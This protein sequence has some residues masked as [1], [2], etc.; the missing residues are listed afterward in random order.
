MR[1]GFLCVVGECG[2]SAVAFAPLAADDGVDLLLYSGEYAFGNAQSF[3]ANGIPI[4]RNFLQWFGQV[5]DGQRIEVSKEFR[6]VNG[7][8]CE[9]GF[10]RNECN[11]R[12]VPAWVIVLLSL[13]I[14]RI[15]DNMRVGQYSAPV[16]CKSRARGHVLIP[17]TPGYDKRRGRRRD[18][19]QNHR[20]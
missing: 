1:C 8:Q 19:N 6:I 17:I 7:D 15:R 11:P 10:M 12:L 16:D 5:A 4:D 9:I 20:G 3:A 2:R 13:H 18:L 14:T